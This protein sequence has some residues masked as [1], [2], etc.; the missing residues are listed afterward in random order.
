MA[1]LAQ[2]ALKAPKDVFP[3]NGKG[4]LLR[5]LCFDPLLQ[6]KPCAY[7][8][9][10]QLGGDCVDTV[11]ESSDSERQASQ[12]SSFGGEYPI[13]VEPGVTVRTV[14][15]KLTLVDSRTTSFQFFWGGD[16][17]KLLAKCRKVLV[18]AG[19]ALAL[20][21][22]AAVAAAGLRGF[23][24]VPP[25]KKVGSGIIFAMENRENDVGSSGNLLRVLSVCARAPFETR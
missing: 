15:N 20:P 17:G 2:L 23:G 5:P 18:A 16:L 11:S 14:H 3:A 13:S 22:A 8:G 4:P 19:A 9:T 21:A 24:G 10:R 1:L 6:E 25:K 7:C 12:A